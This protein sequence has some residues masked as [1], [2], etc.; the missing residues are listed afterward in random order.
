MSIFVLAKFLLSCA[1]NQ[2]LNALAQKEGLL[3]AIS[4]GRTSIENQQSGSLDK[5][6]FDS[7]AKHTV[8]VTIQDKSENVVEISSGV[9][10]N[11]SFIVTSA[12]LFEKYKLDGDYSGTIYFGSSGNFSDRAQ[13]K[14]SKNEFLLPKP[15]QIDNISNTPNWSMLPGNKDFVFIRLNQ[16]LPK[17]F[18]KIIMIND[19]SF[20]KAG[21]SYHAAGFGYSEN[22][23]FDYQLRNVDIILS[24][25]N[26]KQPSKFKEISS[27]LGV[28]DLN[29]FLEFSATAAATVLHGDS[30]GPIYY[31]YTDGNGKIVCYLAGIITAHQEP[32]L[33]CK[34]DPSS[35]SIADYALRVDA[36][37]NDAISV[38]TRIVQGA[39]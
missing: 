29:Y 30:G 20:F 33:N 14:F 1:P 31:E 19:N 18:E 10:L 32:S 13:Q 8:L 24:R 35:C 22:D 38:A 5:K 2:T 25:S 27:S 15:D 26:T 39:L 3:T 36:F 21:D 7:I 11:E 34:N 28:E 16:G 12:H 9:I 6:R 4:G 37:Y 23:R 17:G